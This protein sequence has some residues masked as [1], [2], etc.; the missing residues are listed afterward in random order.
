[1]LLGFAQQATYSVWCMYSEIQEN[2]SEST[3]KYK[4]I[5]CDVGVKLL[6]VQFLK[7]VMVYLW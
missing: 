1:M 5:A 6:Y 3:V 7:P 2:W 4:W